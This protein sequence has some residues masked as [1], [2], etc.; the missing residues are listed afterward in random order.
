[1]YSQ[2]TYKW[3]GWEIK[4]DKLQEIL[5]SINEYYDFPVFPESIL[6]RTTEVQL[7]SVNLNI[8]IYENGME[9][10][11]SLPEG[12]V[13]SI[14]AKS[15]RTSKWFDKDLADDDD[16]T[17]TTNEKE[18]RERL[19]SAFHSYKRK[20][21]KELKKG[22]INDAM[23]NLSK[24]ISQ[25]ERLVSA[26]GLFE[27]FGGS[28]NVRVEAQLNGFRVGD[29]LGD[30]PFISNSLGELGADKIFGPLQEI[31]RKIGMTQSEFFIYW[32]LNKI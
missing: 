13:N 23:K 29:N 27:L 32:L 15:T 26:E 14:L 21:G 24:L 11:L 6:A 1:M 18:F 10:F 31:Q 4:T 22:D 17:P 20:Y 28:E 3:R 2:I 9:Y 5:D 16:K 8:S 7:Y 19:I 25:A 12:R 30:K